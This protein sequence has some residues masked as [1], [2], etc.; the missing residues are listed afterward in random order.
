[1]TNDPN[2]LSCAGCTNQLTRF[3]TGLFAEADAAVVQEHLDS[4]PN[5]R[6]FSDQIDAVVDFVGSGEPV[7]VPE[8]VSSLLDDFMASTV[9]QP[10]DV[11]RTIGSLCRLAD[12]LDPNNAEDLVQ[13]TL[14]AALEDDPGRLELSVLAQNLTDRAF[15]DSGPTLRSL[16]EYETR[17]ESRDT[18]PDPDGD[19]AELFYPDF[20]ADGPDAGRHVDAPN[21]W[22]QT[23][24]LSPDDDVLTAEMYGVVNDAIARLAD[25]LGQLVQL[26]DIDD[27]SVANAAKTLRLDENDA[28]DA[29]QRARVHLRGVVDSVLAV[30]S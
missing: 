14:L 27:V 8:S 10:G 5:C 30:R 18:G 4:C 1:M 21:R 26:V 29:L 25:P 24:T 16:D 12:S 15:G 3:Q 6:L 7:D 2:T 17:T 19:T 23:N 28:A 11:T 20:Y 13:Q 9:H 22:G